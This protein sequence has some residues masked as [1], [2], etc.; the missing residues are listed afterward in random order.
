M[1]HS[2][3]S[4]PNIRLCETLL[5][6]WVGPWK[7]CDE[8]HRLSLRRTCCLERQKGDAWANHFLAKAFSFGN[9]SDLRLRDILHPDDVAHL[10]ESFRDHHH[11]LNSLPSLEIDAQFVNSGG[12]SDFDHH[13]LFP[14][15]SHRDCGGQLQSG[16]CNY[17]SC[18]LLHPSLHIIHLLGHLSSQQK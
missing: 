15:L 5:L 13:R 11:L 7:A 17:W 1:C 3:H 9:F 2:L 6:L 16:V 8:E 18:S 12:D 14:H 4:N 10:V